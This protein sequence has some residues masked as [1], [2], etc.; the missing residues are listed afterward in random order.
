MPD[1][2]LDGLPVIDLLEITPNTT[3]VAQWTQ[4]DQSSVSRIY[5]QVSNRLGL[6]FGKQRDGLYRAGANQALLDGLRQSSQW[7]R[8]HQQP[9]ELRWVGHPGNG[10]LQRGEPPVLPPAL[11]RH[12]VGGQRT[13]ALLE[14]RVLDLAVVEAAERPPA[15]GPLTAV[16]L[17]RYRL[18]LA[19]D[20][21][22]PLQGMG[23]LSAEQLLAYPLVQDPETPG[24]RPNPLFC[25]SPL[26][27]QAL[28]RV[29]PLEPLPWTSQRSGSDVILVRTELLSCAAIDQLI[30]AI[31]A[32][33]RR[34]FEAL[35]GLDWSG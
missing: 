33:Y 4:R 32:G 16:P 6:H 7:L 28:Q 14:Q 26:R 13:A 24:P 35:P 9:S 31:R 10:P 2:L 29:R 8:L 21:H 3:A 22:H 1:I 12:W 27:L 23:P 20:P 18:L 5:R 25:L 15:G 19:A 11:E 30:Q 17:V 34:H